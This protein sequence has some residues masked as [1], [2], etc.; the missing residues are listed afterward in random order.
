MDYKSLPGQED[1]WDGYTASINKLK[2]NPDVVEFDRLCF[3]VF[4]KTEAGAL[5]LSQ[6]TERYLIPS[7]PSRGENYAHSCIYYEG[8]RDCIR[9]L[10][11]STKGY[12]SRK[13]AEDKKKIKETQEKS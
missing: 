7:T 13:E 10:I 2:N 8:F 3:E 11:Q 4:N 1:Y 6:L 9:L 5:L 12:K